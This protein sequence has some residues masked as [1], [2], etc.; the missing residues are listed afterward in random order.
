MTG[1]AAT[2]HAIAFDMPSAAPERSRI[3]ALTA[4]MKDGDEAAFREFHEAYFHRLFRYLYVAL[5]GDAVAAQD[6]LQETLL[7]VVRHVRRFDDEAA[8]WGWLTRLARSA[9]V[10]HG[11]RISRTQRL[12][13]RFAAETAETPDS[14]PDLWPLVESA[15]ERLDASDQAIL[16][17]KYEG[18]AAIGEIAATL[19]ISPDAAESRLARARRSLRDLVFQLLKHEG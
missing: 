18:N 9:A 19:Q 8:F 16:R 14:Q 4:L 10:D 6:V 15:L 7:R 11:R 2:S 1:R 3:A 17:A 12:L 13:G 5:N